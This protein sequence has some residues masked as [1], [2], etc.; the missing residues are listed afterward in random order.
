MFTEDIQNKI[1]NGNTPYFIFCGDTCSQTEAIKYFYHICRINHL[2]LY[3][4]IWSKKNKRNIFS[5][6]QAL[7]IYKK[8]FNELQDK[9][10]KI[11]YQL[12]ILGFDSLSEKEIIKKLKIGE[13]PDY[14]NHK[15]QKYNSLNF[16][17]KQL[18]NYKEDFIKKLTNRKKFDNNVY[19]PMFVVLG[20]HELSQFDSIDT[21][22]KS[23]EIFF[24]KEKIYFLHNEI[25]HGARINIL[26]GIGFAKYNELY[27]ANN[28]CTT[29]PPITREEEIKETEK[30][31][32]KYND[33]VL[34]SLKENK[35]LLVVSHYPVRDWLFKEKYSSIC[36]Y[37]SGHTHNNDSI[38][39]EN[40][41]VYANNQIGYKKKGIRF[42]LAN[43][44]MNYNPFIDYKDGVYNIEPIQYE[45][46]LLH[47]GTSI[48]GTYFI[49]EQLKT[50]NA[51]FY[52]IK[53][54]GFYG[55]FVINKKTGTKICFG[56]RLKTIS[57]VTDI[58]YF[59]KSFSTIIVKYFNILA[60]YRKEQERISSRLKEMGLDGKIHGS[61]IDVDFYY[62]ILLDP[63]TGEKLFYFSPVFG[64]IKQ[65]RSFSEMICDMKLNN[66]LIGVNEEK[67]MTIKLDEEKGVD[68]FVFLNSKNT[69]YKI[70]SKINQL[71]SLFE[72]NILREWNDYLVQETL[73]RGNKFL[74]ERQVVNAKYDA[75]CDNIVEKKLDEFVEIY[76]EKGFIIW[77]AKKFLRQEIMYSI[78]RKFIST[79]YDVLSKY[80]EVYY[81]YYL[82]DKKHDSCDYVEVSCSASRLFEIHN[83]LL[84]LKF[85]HNDVVIRLDYDE[86]CAGITIY[87]KGT[88]DNLNYIGT[89]I[90]EGKELIE[91]SNPYFGI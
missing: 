71:Q 63:I 76:E 81:Q 8:K 55:F 89:F 64:A 46:F 4:K 29:T 17:L 80:S 68:D 19:L 38:H 61:I 13:Y 31:V 25:I 2:Y 73:N 69:L 59:Y 72:T 9:V 88:K 62:H 48:T 32:K 91:T 50:G 44:G 83:K 33:A 56:G 26:G 51:T 43:L 28:L 5:Q 65:F 27:N 82:Y 54:E 86:N 85:G 74:I 14:I 75:E 3:Y 36:V 7:E 10:K 6:K 90:Y 47:N 52:M 41:Q 1:K 45:K 39:T 35:P 23:F 30:F 37:F 53:Q 49:D 84:S 77:K 60:P 78:C 16:K 12:K 22:V 66:A 70:S 24:K 42:K 18:K 58:N 79:Y 40:I 11:K 87:L 20:N 21:C 34:E 67:M 57:K 15:I